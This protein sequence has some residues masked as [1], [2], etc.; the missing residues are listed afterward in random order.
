MRRRRFQASTAQHRSRA[1]DYEP[2]AALE[3]GS[4]MDDEEMEP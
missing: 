4:T 1:N 2:R 3:D